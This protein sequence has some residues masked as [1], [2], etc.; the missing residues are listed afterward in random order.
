M[1]HAKIDE[2][3][4]ETTKLLKLSLKQNVGISSYPHENNDENWIYAN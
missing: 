1:R 2:T 3:L 4:T